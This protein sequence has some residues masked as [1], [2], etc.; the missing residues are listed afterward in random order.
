MK[1]QRGN[2][3]KVSRLESSS[4]VKDPIQSLT[5]PPE[6][7]AVTIGNENGM[8]MSDATNGFP[9]TETNNTL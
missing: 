5:I 8:E 1:A 4:N 6:P 3:Q 9:I 2:P 7:P